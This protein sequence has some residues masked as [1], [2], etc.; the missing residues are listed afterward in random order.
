M[1]F[2]VS[3]MTATDEDRFLFL[4]YSSRTTPSPQIIT[5]DKGPSLGVE[6][7]ELEVLGTYHIPALS[8]EPQPE[9]KV[10]QANPFP[11]SKM[12]VTVNFDQGKI[13]E[14]I[15]LGKETI[16]V[17]AALIRTSDLEKGL[18]ENMILSEMDALTFVANEC[19]AEETEMYFEAD[20]SGTVTKTPSQNSTANPN[21]DPNPGG[22]TI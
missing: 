11:T 22:K 18:L 9:T 10:G 2:L 1:S 3:D 19:P 17:Q 20:V 7:S 13:D 5:T 16:Y 4:V 12:T 15:R 14:M 21:S 6:M 8:V